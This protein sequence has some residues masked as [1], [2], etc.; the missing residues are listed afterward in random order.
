MELED[1]VEFADDDEKYYSIVWSNK[2]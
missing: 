2:M 1:I